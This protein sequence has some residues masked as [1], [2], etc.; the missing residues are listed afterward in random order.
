[1]EL[2]PVPTRQPAARPCGEIIVLVVDDDDGFRSAVV[3]NLRDDGHPVLECQDPSEVPPL[4]GLNQVALVVTDYHMPVIDGLAF[5]D[6]FHAVHPGVP[7]V[8]VSAQWTPDVTTQATTRGF[9]RVLHKPI[10]YDDLHTL[11]H[12]LLC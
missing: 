1:M 5:A 7:V 8:L 12:Q 9:M 3:D 2:S 4:A 11:L 10:D 6:A